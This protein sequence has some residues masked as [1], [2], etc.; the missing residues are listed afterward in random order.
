MGSELIIHCGGRTISREELATLEAPPPSERYRPFDFID[1][2][3]M[4]EKQVNR[5]FP[6][7]RYFINE[8]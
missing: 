3:S 7:G 6:G 4:V 8:A 5:E 1:I 2:V